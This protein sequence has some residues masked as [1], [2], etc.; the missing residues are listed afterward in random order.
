M[1]VNEEIFK[2]YDIRGVYPDELTDEFA[3][4]LG[5]AFVEYRNA[6]K[7]VVG[8][9]VR[10]SS[11]PLFIKLSK[12]I[13]DAG[14]TVVDIGIVSTDALYFTVGKFD[15]D[16][17]I[18]ITA[19]HN[20]PKYNGFKICKEEA[21]PLSGDKGLHELKKLIQN[22]SYTES[23][24]AGKK[25]IRNIDKDYIEHTL[26]F[27]DVDALKDFDVV[28]DAGNGVA[29]KIVGELFEH[30]PLNLIPLYFELDGSF[31]NHLPSPLE[32]E[33]T[34]DLREKV[35]ENNADLGV[36]FDGDADRMFLVDENGQMLGGDIVT[37]LVAENILKKDSDNTI[38]YNL[39][40]S[41]TVPEIIEKYGAKPIRSR[42]GHA[43]IKPLMKQ[44]N[45]IFGGEHSGHFYFRDNWYA[46]S[47]VIAFLICVE[48]ISNEDKKLSQLVDDID[49][50]YRSGEINSEVPDR[51]KTI[52]R[53]KEH[54]KEEAKSV[55]ELDGVTIEFEDWWFN[56]RPSN[57]EPVVRLN[58]EAESKDLVERKAADVLEIVRTNKG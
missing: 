44:H 38:V 3:Y 23:E 16:G 57:T 11:N 46:D 18:M 48:L 42:V 5:R 6:D 40:C 27:I 34:K 39:I 19:S 29:G 9:D 14:A 45:A 22:E 10:D 25:I 36:A 54:F 30:L 4:H 51:Q 35:T 13:Q 49:D 52:Q 20:P 12:G 53:V 8:R 55:D 1:K 28:V 37:A 15:Y 2:A 58:L 26:S 43:L 56:L 17:G 33:N 47:G 21:V 50:Y 31:P 24:Q 7:V 41:K 32:P